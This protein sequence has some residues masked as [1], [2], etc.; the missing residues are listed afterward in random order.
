MK[1]LFLLSILSQVFFHSLCAEESSISTSEQILANPTSLVNI[2]SIP[3]TLV[4]QVNVITGDFIDSQVDL[5]LVG[6]EPLVLERFYSSSSYKDGSIC[7]GWNHTLWGMAVKEKG[8]RH[9]TAVTKGGQGGEYVYR[10]LK[11]ETLTLHPEL[12]KT[13]VTN[14]AAGKING[15]TNVKNN[16]LEFREESCELKTGDG[17]SHRYG[18]ISTSRYLLNKVTKANGINHRYRYH[19]DNEHLKRYFIQTYAGD[20]INAI[21]MTPMVKINPD[22]ATMVASSEDGR[23]VTYT[24]IRGHYPLLTSVE[25]SNGPRESFEYESPNKKPRLKKKSLPDGRFLKIKYDD[26]S[27]VSCLEAPAGEGGATIPIYR[28]E[29]QFSGKK[30]KKSTT[31]YTLVYDALNALTKYSYSLENYRLESIQKFKGDQPYTEEKFYWG[32]EGS[33]T[34]AQLVTHTLQEGGDIRYCRHYEYD[35]RGN[36]TTR[37]LLGNLRGLNENP[38]T[39]NGE[40]PNLDSS[41][42]LIK[43]SVYSN[44]NLLLEATEEN[45]TI[46]YTYHAGTNLVEAKYQMSHGRIWEREFFLYDQDLAAVKLYIRDNGTDFSRENLIGVTERKIEKIINRRSPPYGLPEIIE[47]YGLDQGVEKLIKKTV[48]HYDSWGR[49]VQEDHYDSEGVFCYALKW[50]YDNYGNVIKE[51][52][53]VGEVTER[54]Y[55]SNSNKVYETNPCG[56]RRFEYDLMNRLTKEYHGKFIIDNSYDAKGNKIIVKDIC[57][58]QTHYQYDDLGNL[59]KETL[60]PVLDENKNIYYPE[61]RYEYDLFENQTA[62]TDPKGH[63]TR[64][65][66]TITGKPYLKTFPDGTSEHFHYSLKGELIYARDK[67]GSWTTYEY[68]ERSRPIRASTYSPSAVLL[69]RVEKEYDPFHL[70]KETHLSGKTIV[71]SYDFAGRVSTVLEN[72]Q[73]TVYGYDT[74]GRQ[75]ETKVYYNDNGYI[76]YR[77]KYDYLDRI[78]QETTEDPLGTIF[79]NTRYVYDANG[80]R[81]QIINGDSIVK[82]DFDYFGNP[83]KEIDPEGNVTT[84]NYNYNF[85]NQYGVTVLCKETID[86]LGNRSFDIEDAL[87][88][89]E[90]VIRQ[91]DS[92]KTVQQAEYVYDRAGNLSR[93]IERVITPNAPDQQILH[94]WLYDNMNRPIELAEAVAHPES[95]NTK[96]FYDRRGNLAKKIKPDGVIL[97]TSYDALDRLVERKSSDGSIYESYEYNERGQLVRVIEPN[98]ET[99]LKY[100]VQGRVIEEVLANGLKLGYEYDRLGRITKLIYPDQSSSLYSYMGPHLKEI[101]RNASDPYTHQYLSYNQLGDVTD[102]KLPGQCGEVV[103]EYDQLGRIRSIHAPHWKENDLV[104]DPSGDLITL[105]LHDCKGE[106]FCRYRYDPLHQL[107]EEDGTECNRYSYDSLYNRLSKNKTNYSYND[108]CFLKECKYDPNGNLISDGEK[109]YAY[110]ALD[111]LIGLRIGDRHITYEYDYRDRRITKKEADRQISYLYQDQKEI[112]AFEKERP[113]QLRL[114][115]KGKGAEIGAAV[116]CEFGGKPFVPVHDHQGNCIALL[117]LKGELVESYRYNAFGLVEALD[118]E[119]GSLSDPINPWRYVSKRSDDES[120]FVYFGKR[121]YH[122]VLGRW[123]TPDPAGFV[124]GMNLY[125]YVGNNPHR[126]I[127]ID[128]RF[129]WVFAVELFALAWGATATASSTTVAVVGTQQILQAVAA[130]CLVAGKYYCDNHRRERHHRESFHPYRMNQNIVEEDEETKKRG[131]KS[132]SEFTKDNPPP[133][134]GAELGADPGKCP[135][136]GFEWRGKG[137]T[138]SREGSW[139]KEETRESLHPDIHHP[140]PEK[141]HWDYHTQNGKTKLYLDGTWK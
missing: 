95:K 125:N 70:I 39:L 30:K 81:T 41:D 69:N 20:V 58:N 78:V 8:K 82:T 123:L 22:Q 133:Y 111:R 68:D 137:K 66:Y 9:L 101:T 91:D 110:D 141:P 94:V 76:L 19:D 44:D 5:V 119:G 74:L 18:R 103:Y 17:S 27:Q 52:N 59:I 67:D 115:G 46:K 45:A 32:K 80:N 104:Y 73:L 16:T 79:R 85:L 38:V 89:K 34:D 51:T 108:L 136:E 88:R 72:D 47:E 63:T 113:L 124:N 13:G 84:F 135:G 29:Y 33:N 131:K 127:D 87:G 60:P 129:F 132:Q 96:F 25:R 109:T 6:S 57:N 114:L 53:A 99:L 43:R 50:E 35:T 121:Y 98:K 93:W 100:D 77:K 83:I 26:D 102:T 1:L 2:E 21:E 126:Y 64:T 48:N 12:L 14:C 140:P 107:I 117:N 24:C 118:K 23:K 61:T 15:R 65:K 116:A 31:G 54:R 130:T 49:L 138:G 86:P 55:D 10:A 92:G 4:H 134:N 40:V 120:G 90:L 105:Q 56:D 122:P 37:Y 106:T 139:V 36:V 11:G 28:F 62:K 71:Y 97:F 42:C 128:G 112:G 75:S 3:S 7:G